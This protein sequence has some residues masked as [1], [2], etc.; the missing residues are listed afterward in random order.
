MLH[1]HEILG[2]QKTKHIGLAMYSHNSSGGHEWILLSIFSV[3]LVMIAQEENEWISLSQSVFTLARFNFQS[4]RS[5]SREFSRLITLCQ[6]VLILAFTI[7]WFSDPVPHNEWHLITDSV[8]CSV[9]PGLLSAKTKKLL[10]ISW[11]QTKGQSC[12]SSVT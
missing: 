12:W 8:S 1:V 5:I 10:I 4:C 11:S 6:P 7:R 9:A 2:L 3:A